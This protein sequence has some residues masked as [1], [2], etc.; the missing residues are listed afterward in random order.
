MHT[1]LLVNKSYVLK[2]Y[3]VLKGLAIK[4]QDCQFCLSKKQLL[5]TMKFEKIISADHS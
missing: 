3:I 1:Q 5:P 2:N 4:M